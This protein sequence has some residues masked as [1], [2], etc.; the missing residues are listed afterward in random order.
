[1]LQ[2]AALQQG[3]SCASKQQGQFCNGAFSMLLLLLLCCCA[4]L[5]TFLQTFLQL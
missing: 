3:G 4:I 2:G 1:M 5:Q